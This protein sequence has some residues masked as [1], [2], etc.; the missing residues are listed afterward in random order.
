MTLEEKLSTLTGSMIVL[1]GIGMLA[2][3]LALQI[4]KAATGRDFALGGGK[5]PEEAARYWADQRFARRDNPQP[6]QVAGWAVRQHPGLA[7]LDPDW[8]EG[9]IR[10]RAR[11]GGANWSFQEKG[12]PPGQP[13]GRAGVTAVLSLDV[14]AAAPGR[15][16]FTATITVPFEITV[17]PHRIL[18]A[19]PA[20]NFA[21]VRTAPD[22]P[23]HGPRTGPGR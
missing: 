6:G 15:K 18:S 7:G 20:F 9:E 3:I 23:A 21:T 14:P 16:A 5:S 17:T 19:E 22:G 4:N 12:A 10:S 13:P 2:V 8:L 11:R 1:A